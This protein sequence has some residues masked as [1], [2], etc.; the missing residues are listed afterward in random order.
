VTDFIAELEAE[1]LEA[2]R[3]RAAR[4]RRRRPLLRPRRLVPVAVASAALLVIVVALRGIE[5]PNDERAVSPNGSGVEVVLPV[6]APAAACEQR[7]QRVETGSDAPLSVFAR[8][9]VAADALPDLAGGSLPATTVRPGES[10][11]AGDVHLVLADGIREDGA[12]V[13]PE[14]HHGGK[15]VCL[16]AGQDD[17]VVRCFDDAT[18][19]ANRAVARTGPDQVHGIVADGVE[20]LKLEWD[21]GAADAD[22]ADNAY[23]AATPG[24]EAGDAVRVIPQH[25][26]AG[27]V[28]SRELLELVPVMTDPS[29]GEP[30][31]AV[32][33]AMRRNGARGAWRRWA[34]LAVV[35]EDV[36]LWVAP[37]LPCDNAR[38]PEE[39]A[40]VV[41]VRP[42][43]Q[44]RNLCG[45]P[46]DESRLMVLTGTGRFLIAGLGPPRTGPVVVTRHGRAP[47]TVMA[48]GGVFGGMLPEGFGPT[49]DGASGDGVDVTFPDGADVAV[50]NATTE[51][52]LA[53]AVAGRLPGAEVEVIGSSHQQRRERSSVFFAHEWARHDAEEVARRL[54]IADVRRAPPGVVPLANTR[55]IVVVGEDMRSR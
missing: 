27:C 28:P 41:A 14:E 53:T 2:A 16:V 4:G 3:R 5:G 44:P 50:L 7:D 23:A 34:R 45:H 35:D 22:V 43:E 24:L 36:E 51:E 32:A 47:V 55:V 20:H 38:A 49:G 54:R 6:A 40:C 52:G 13:P 25:P 31:D 30:P 37:N 19:A 9:R 18:I 11:R 39:E 17:V 15:G 21:G 46:A 1:L 33:V 48:N 26:E 29:Q 12:C 10:R 42:G 8:E